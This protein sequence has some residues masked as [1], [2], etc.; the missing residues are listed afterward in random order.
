MNWAL[1]QDVP[2]LSGKQHLDPDDHSVTGLMIFLPIYRQGFEHG[3]GKVSLNQWELQ[4][5]PTPQLQEEA[6]RLLGYQAWL[7]GLIFG[8]IDIR[9]FLQHHLGTNAPIVTFALYAS[10]NDLPGVLP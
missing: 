3:D 2:A 7:C 8:G 4:G 1:G 6:K 10:T 9:A 5:A